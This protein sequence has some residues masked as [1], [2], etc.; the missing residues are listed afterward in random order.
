M[1]LENNFKDE[2]TGLLSRYEETNDQISLEEAQAIIAI[3][4]GILELNSLI[5]LR[6]ELMHIIDKLPGKFFDFLPFV[7]ALKKQL[8]LLLNKPEYSLVNIITCEASLLREENAQLK[9]K[10]TQIE[11]S[12][13]HNHYHQSATDMGFSHRISML[14]RDYLQTNQ[15]LRAE[16]KQLLIQLNLAK[17]THDQLLESINKMK[18]QVENSDAKILELQNELE[19]KQAEIERL[20]A[21]NALLKKAQQTAENKNRGLGMW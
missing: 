7:D 8:R 10:L 9:I 21:E 3:R 16:N 6:Q 5:Q 20:C 18:T 19:V 13:Q 1:G 12:S 4:D 11:S 14:E 2:L 17:D 15:L